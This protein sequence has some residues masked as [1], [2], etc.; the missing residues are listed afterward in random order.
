MKPTSDMRVNMENLK[1]FPV[2]SSTGQG[3]SLEPLLFNIEVLA[4]AIGQEK[5]IK[6]K[7]ERKKYTYLF[8]DDMIIN[9]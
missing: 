6:S 4:R 9:V 1:T 5:E 2:R 7:S 8:A 3:C